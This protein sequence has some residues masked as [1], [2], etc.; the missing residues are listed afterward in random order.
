M[1]VI[2]KSPFE[3]RVICGP[4]ASLG[5]HARMMRSRTAS[6]ALKSLNNRSFSLDAKTMVG[7][8]QEEHLKAVDSI[9]VT[10]SNARIIEL[11][12]DDVLMGLRDRSEACAYAVRQRVL[13]GYTITMI[14]SALVADMQVSVRFEHSRSG[15]ADYTDK[16]LALQQLAVMFEGDV[17]STLSGEIKSRG[18]V[19]GVRDD[20]YLSALSINFVDHEKFARNTRHIGA[21]HVVLLEPDGEVKAIK[22]ADDGG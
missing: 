13:N 12:D 1:T 22:A 8:K 3:A 7:L 19:L 16:A 9:T 2:R 10:L 6:S 18:L 5:P 11:S 17:T 20:E 15:S 4:E 14:S 21:D